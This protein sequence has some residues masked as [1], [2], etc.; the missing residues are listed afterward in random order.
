MTNPLR[1]SSPQPCSG[2]RSP[3]PPPPS[4][5]PL[6]AR[7]PNSTIP[8][9]SAR[10]AD[11]GFYGFSAEGRDVRWAPTPSSIDCLPHLVLHRW[12]AHTFG[13]VSLRGRAED[14]RVEP[15]MHI[16]C[17]NDRRPG[18]ISN[19]LE[20]TGNSG[21][22]AGC[23]TAARSFHNALSLQFSVCIYIYVYTYKLYYKYY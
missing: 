14:R 15:A 6:R 13:D 1:A 7:G 2:A 19:L 4:E 18:N 22:G 12:N 9:G 10:T 23:T 21:L 16:T 8:R 11:L 17:S 5:T 3:K 20:P